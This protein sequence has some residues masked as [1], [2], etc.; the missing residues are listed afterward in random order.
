MEAIFNKGLSQS[1][2]KVTSVLVPHQKGLHTQI[3]SYSRQSADCSSLCSYQ[4]SLPDILR[5]FSK[6]VG[7]PVATINQMII[8]QLIFFDNFFF[9]RGVGY[10]ELLTIVRWWEL[11]CSEHDFC[12]EIVAILR[13]V[14][15]RAK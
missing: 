10:C 8:F 3:K 2:L 4:G 5:Y 11:C 9:R 13:S 12:Q 15:G 7:W 6:V 1:F 14:K